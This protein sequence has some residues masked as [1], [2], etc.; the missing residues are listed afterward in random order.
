MRSNACVGV[1]VGCGVF[2]QMR[3]V[4]AVRSSKNRPRALFKPCYRR[5]FAPLFF[6]ALLQG[7]SPFFFVAGAKGSR[8]GSWKVVPL[9][10]YA[11]GRGGS[12]TVGASI[13][14]YELKKGKTHAPTHTPITFTKALSLPVFTGFL[15][16]LAGVRRSVGRC[17]LDALRRCAG[18]LHVESFAWRSAVG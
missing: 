12:P 1:F 9:E 15:V 17:R 13:K 18:R 8:L 16:C 14:G 3:G 2:V 6:E 11:R 5:L 10:S 4:S 7:A